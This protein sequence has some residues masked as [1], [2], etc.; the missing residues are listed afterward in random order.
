MRIMVCHQIYNYY[1]YEDEDVVCSFAGR[2]K[3]TIETVKIK[4]YDQKKRLLPMPAPKHFMEAFY[5]LVEQDDD[6]ICFETYDRKDKFWFRKKTLQ[7]W[8]INASH[9]KLVELLQR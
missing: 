5:H 9:L 8:K 7:Y 4:M 6:F 3:E 2:T 1:E